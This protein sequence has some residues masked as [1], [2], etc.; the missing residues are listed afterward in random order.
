MTVKADLGLARR[1]E[2]AEA[3]ANAA[4]IE[5][6]RAAENSTGAEWI[7][8][9]GAYAMFDNIESPL[10]QTFG[11]GA[12]D[13]FGDREFEVVEQF[14][15]DHGAPTAHEVCSFASPDTLSLL[16][17]R[18]YTPIEA[19]VVHVRPLGSDVGASSPG[20]GVRA[21]DPS[22][23]ALWSRTAAEGWASDMPQAREFLETLGAV[24]ARA[25]GTT[26]FVAEQKGLPIATASLN[27]QNGVALLAGASTIPSARR[28]GAQQALFN[29]RIAFARERGIDLAMVTQP[30]TAS[31]RNAERQGFRAVYTRAKWMRLSTNGDRRD[32]AL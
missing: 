17:A 26:C 20:I 13:P 12:F 9:A 7:E 18:G 27:L 28:Q 24:M 30:G 15:T 1:L 16:S 25:G 19:S 5:A 3:M 22:E 23:A 4:S 6:R 29:A 2:R 21:I 10:T 32:G 31:R 8:V 14:F 11:I